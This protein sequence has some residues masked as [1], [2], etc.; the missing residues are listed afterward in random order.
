MAS[1]TSVF[2]TSGG[3]YDYEHDIQASFLTAMIIKGGLPVFPNGKITEIC[4]QCKNKGYKT[5]DLFVQAEDVHGLHRILVQ[6]KYNIS[7]TEKN[8]TFIE[9]MNSFWRDFN[10]TKLFDKTKDKLF[11]IKSGLTNEDR[12]HICVILDWASTHKDEN[13]F[14][15]EVERIDV[16]NQ[17]LAVFANILKRVNNNTS[18]SKKEIWQ[19]LNCFTLLSYDFGQKNS[20]DHA[21]FLNW[22]GLTKTNSSPVPNLEI[23]NSINAVCAEFNRNGGSIDLESICRLDVF[24]YFDSSF[25]LNTKESLQKIVDSSN[26]VFKPISNTIKGFHFNRTEIRQNIIHSINENQVSFITGTPG[27]GKSAVIKELLSVELK[28]ALP[29]IFKADQFNIPTLSQVFT[30]IGITHNLADLMSSISL[31]QHKIIII[32]SAEKLL[33]GDP[34]NS[35]RQLLETIKETPDLK[36]LITC[37]SYAVNIIVQK[38]NIAGLNVIEIPLLNDLELQDAATEFN[39][40]NRLLANKQIKEILKSPKYLEFTLTAID[41]DEFRSGK[42][43]LTDFKNKLW[44]QIIENGNVVKNGIARKREKTFHH[45]TIGRAVNMQLFFHPLDSEIDYE[46]VEELVNDNIISKNGLKYEFTPSH[47]ILEDWALVRHISNLNSNL[48]TGESLFTELGNQPALR[49]AFR[50]WIEDLILTEIDKVLKLVRTTLLNSEIERYWADEIL[51]AIFR[52]ENCSAFFHGFKKELIADNARLLNRSI[53]ICRTTCKEYSFKENTAKDILLPVGSAWE[54]LLNF[55]AINY[56][57]LTKIQNSIISFLLDWEY[58]YLF[59]PSKCSDAEI[60]DAKHIAINFIKEIEN[61]VQFWSSVSSRNR[62]EDLIY[63]IFGFADNDQDGEIKNLLSRTIES[64]NQNHKREVR[65]IY[66]KI[67][68]KALG[69]F[70]NQKL[71]YTYP[72]PIISLAEIVWKDTADKTDDDDDESFPPY[73]HRQRKDREESWG[74]DGNRLDFFP[75]GLYKTFVYSLLESN[76]GKGIAF[77]VDFTNYMIQSYA[78]SEYAQEDNLETVDFHLNSGLRVPKYISAT[79]WRAY[80][81]NSSTHDLLES[82]L[83]SFEKYMLK[84]ADTNDEEVK[85]HFSGFVDYC[86]EEGNSVTLVS[87]LVSVF[88]AQPRTFNNSILPILRCKEC[89]ALDLQRAIS[90]GSVHAMADPEISFA[91][92]EKYDSNQLP[93]R[94]KFTSGLRSFLPIYQFNI[95]LL[96]KEIFEILDNFHETCGED[97]FWQKAIYEMDSRTYRASKTQGNNYQLKIETQYPDTILSA[98]KTYTEE[99]NYEDISIQFSG[100]IHKVLDGKDSI[101]LE[102]WNAVFY[103]YTQNENQYSMYDM[104]ASLA[105]IGIEKYAD[106]ITEHQK[107]WSL[108]TIATTLIEI[109]KNKNNYMRSMEQPS[110]NIMDEEPVLKGCHLL[111]IHIQDPDKVIELKMIIAYLLTSHLA[112]HHQKE[113]TEYFRTVFFEIHPNISLELW[114]LLISYAKFDIENKPVYYG[115]EEQFREY[116]EKK[117]QFIFNFFSSD[118]TE[119][120]EDFT[121]ETHQAYYL[122]VALLLVN[123]EAVFSSQRSFI[124][125]ISELILKDQNS[126]NNYSH[127]RS[128]SK[129]KLQSTI[130]IRAQFAL[131]EILLYNE[132]GFCKELLNVLIK[133]FLDLN[134]ITKHQNAEMYKFSKEIFSTLITRFNDIIVLKIDADIEKYGRQ[135]WE[136]WSELFSKLKPTAKNYFAQEMLLDSQWP[137]QSDNWK[138]FIDKKPFYEELLQYYGTNNF[139]SVLKV[140]STFGEKFL[141]PEHLPTLTFFLKA[142]P[143][144][145][146]KLNSKSGR[147]LIKVLFNNHISEIK[148]N[149]GLVTDFITILNNMVERGVSEAYIIRESVITYKNK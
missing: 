98:V 122:V 116:N 31:L 139:S 137:I 88:L 121:F 81:G 14:F 117:H 45:I 53:L 35:F 136:L 76:P 106:E 1:E 8:E 107:N 42:I 40:I 135:F 144:N 90:E 36:L 11:L 15:S 39:Q 29:F 131:N 3:G 20:T 59:L 102:N 126:E 125:K 93:H 89:Y 41:R 48:A 60:A 105:V 145:A 120:N 112:D 30:Q 52:S 79:L 57:E 75:A 104:P 5:D 70:R 146:E 96:N 119:V 101:T 87:V 129:R 22:I 77:V 37:R 85:K 61:D 27:V 108:E 149:Q 148:K 38:Y 25:T 51:T 43:T 73:L 92:K 138:G 23:W 147:M 64:Q 71:I 134:Y 65:E 115:S 47:D 46:A 63:L 21:H 84:L 74:I 127:Q 16:K 7:L 113:Y 94:K 133:P 68:L 12:N 99:R 10:N 2:Q 17:K 97:L 109:V 78:G 4:F 72:D 67:S 69:G 140:L 80:R 62:I 56:R 141:L 142:Q 118:K 13:D 143:D 130:I 100:L 55:I 18:L 66:N 28:D 19:F 34:D 91:Q 49:R 111:F 83:I 54:A 24:T 123:R 44:F 124:L 58:K 6:V 86:L 103:H 33:E 110:Y 32:D 50:L 128:R 95:G 9:V 132:I 82:I 26:F 114:E